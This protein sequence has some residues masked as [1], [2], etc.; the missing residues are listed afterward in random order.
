ML[1]NSSKLMSG[2]RTLNPRATPESG[3]PHSPRPGCFFAFPSNFISC[4]QEA[5]NPPYSE[6]NTMNVILTRQI[7]IKG[8]REMAHLLKCLQCNHQ[9]LSLQPKR[10]HKIQGTATQA[11]NP[12]RRGRQKEPGSLLAGPYR[13]WLSSR[14]SEKDVTRICTYIHTY[15]LKVKIRFRSWRDG[16]AV[17]T[18]CYPSRRS[19]LGSEHSRCL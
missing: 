2:S 19:K 17:K 3:S 9:D 5:Q 14:F 15:A 6:F 11:Y 18:T 4:S 8:T 12:S 10:P 13:E 7:E 16:C 1:N